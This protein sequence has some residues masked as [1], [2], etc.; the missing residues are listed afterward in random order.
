[1]ELPR[2]A[3][4]PVVRDQAVVCRALVDHHGQS[5]HVQHYLTEMIILPNNSRANITRYILEDTDTSGI[6]CSRRHPIVNVDASRSLFWTRRCVHISCASWTAWT[7]AAVQLL[8][9]HNSPNS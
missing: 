8:P 1:M 9:P 5:R 7:A 3:P 6:S 4:A 2:V